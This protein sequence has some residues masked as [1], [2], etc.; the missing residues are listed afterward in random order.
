MVRKI[1]D[2][3]G[4]SNDPEAEEIVATMPRQKP[5]RSKQDYRTPRAFL[6]AV[7]GLLGIEDFTIDLAA[8]VSNSVTTRY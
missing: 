2:Q 4:S 7:K 5:G 6:V 3:A 8:S 1:V